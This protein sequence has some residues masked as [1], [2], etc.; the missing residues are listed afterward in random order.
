MQ[1]TAIDYHIQA[2]PDHILERTVDQACEGRVARSDYS[3][4]IGY[5]EPVCGTGDQAGVEIF[6]GDIQLS[7]PDNFELPDKL[8]PASFSQA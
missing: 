8:L 5:D 2:V 1:T 4:S 7:F 6:C 3:G